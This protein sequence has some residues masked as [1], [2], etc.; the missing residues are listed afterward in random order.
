MGRITEAVLRQRRAMWRART[1]ARRKR[2]MTTRTRAWSKTTSSNAMTIPA[3]IP[4]NPKHQGVYYRPPVVPLYDTPLPYGIQVLIVMLCAALEVV[5]H[6]V[7]MRR[8]RNNN[9]HSKKLRSV[10][11]AVQKDPRTAKSDQLR[12][13]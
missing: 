6:R 2:R 5:N 8:R 10:G 13:Q 4:Q 3:I 9:Y 7:G 1:T 12:D 11:Q